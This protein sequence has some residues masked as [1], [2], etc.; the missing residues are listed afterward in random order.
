[1]VSSR[2]KLTPPC[3][4]SESGPDQ[5]AKKIFVGRFLS[6]F[7]RIPKPEIF[8][9]ISLRDGGSHTTIPGIIYKDYL[10]N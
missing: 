6:E 8:R 2:A 1:M 10:I 4:R 9:A 7:H 3:L 5:E